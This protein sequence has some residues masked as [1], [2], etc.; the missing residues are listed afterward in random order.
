MKPLITLSHFKRNY[1]KMPKKHHTNYYTEHGSYSI[2]KRHHEKCSTCDFTLCAESNPKVDKNTAN[3]ASDTF[4]RFYWR[5]ALVVKIVDFVV[6]GKIRIFYVQFI[7][8]WPKTALAPPLTQLTE[9]YVNLCLKGS[10]LQMHTLYSNYIFVSLCVCVYFWIVFMWKFENISKTIGVNSRQ[11]SRMY[12]AK[13]LAV[14]NFFV[15]I[16]VVG[17]VPSKSNE[18]V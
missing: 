11:C 16:S 8:F 1:V 12:E 9:W 7:A 2:Q 3:C 14:S 15:L 4:D 13:K 10:F 5:S 17:W 6:T 18:C